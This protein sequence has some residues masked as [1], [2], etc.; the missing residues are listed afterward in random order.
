MTDLTANGAAVP[1][2]GEVSA[3]TDANGVA[4]LTVTSTKKVNGN[5]YSVDA[6]TNGQAGT[7]IVATY[8]TAAPSSFK[9]TST[10]AWR[11]PPA[12]GAAQLK[13][14]LLDQY[15]SAYAPTGRTRVRSRCS[16]PAPRQPGNGQDGDL[17]GDHPDAAGV[18]RQL[19]VRVHAGGDADGGHADRLHIRLRQGRRRCVPGTEAGTDGM[20]SWLS[21]AAVANVAVSAPTSSTL[22]RS[23]WP[24]RFNA[25]AAAIQTI[26]AR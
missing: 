7:Q 16:S 2:T 10:S 21:A 18:R 5:A 19:L 4:T 15:G 3:V 25:P 14:Q 13:G 26:T 6:T 11:A 17:E 23:L 8:Q 22:R 1:S 24:V 20:I 12:T 9:V